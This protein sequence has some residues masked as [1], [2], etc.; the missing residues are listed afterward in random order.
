MSAIFPK[1]HVH[2]FAYDILPNLWR[3]VC[4]ETMGDELMPADELFREREAEARISLA[5]LGE[6]PD[7][8][9]AM[10]TEWR[11][12]VLGHPKLD[13]RFE[14]AGDDLV[15]RWKWRP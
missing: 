7:R 10:L 15:I 6:L 2:A 11:D 5:E 1:L 3:C 14:M 9:R 8:G 13:A 12:Y 4:G